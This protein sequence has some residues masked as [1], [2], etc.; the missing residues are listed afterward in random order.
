MRD[1][2]QVARD[3][4]G[5]AL[6]RMY[7]DRPVA[8]MITEV[9]AYGGTDDPASHAYR[10]NR[11]RASIM[12]GRVGVAY[13]YFT[14]GMH[15]CVNV[16]ARPPRKDAG[17]VLIRSGEII[18]GL[19]IALRNR[20]AD[21]CRISS[22]PGNVTKALRIDRSFNGTD[23]ASCSPLFIGSW[24]DIPEDLIGASGRVGI[25][26]GT[27][28]KWRFYIKGNCSV[29]GRSDPKINSMRRL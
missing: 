11:G 12:F 27:E 26:R 2:V 24:A 3:L 20:P 29:S 28:A 5:K 17:A 14:Y 6:V 16:V 9:E 19:D 15:Y 25:R 21:P 1:T 22:G 8:M 13:V 23:M 4:L 18:E 10:G 7:G